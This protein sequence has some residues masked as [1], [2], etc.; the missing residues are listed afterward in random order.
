MGRPLNK[1]LIAKIIADA[2]VNDMSSEIPGNVLEQVATDTFVVET[3]DG[4]APCK[5]TVFPPA[6][7]EMRIKAFDQDGGTYYIMHL[8][9]KTA[10]IWQDT[11]TLI[12]NGAVVPWST[13][14]ADPYRVQMNN[15]DKPGG[16]GWFSLFG[17]LDSGDKDIYDYAGQVAYDSLNNLYMLTGDDTN[18]VAYLVKYDTEGVVEWQVQIHEGT[19]GV[20]DYIVAGCVLVDRNGNPNVMVIDDQ[21]GSANRGPVIMV[22][23]QDDGTVIKQRQMHISDS[24]NPYD[25]EFWGESMVMDPDDGSIYVVGFYNNDSGTAGTLLMKLDSDLNLL[26]QNGFSAADVFQEDFTTGVALTGDGNAWV[27]FSGYNVNYGAR[28]AFV[29]Q[30][31]PNGNLGVTNSWFYSPAPEMG[32]LGDVYNY[33][34]VSDSE[35][36]LVVVGRLQ[37]EV[38][39]VTVTKISGSNAEPQ[40]ATALINPDFNLNMYG[41]VTDGTDIYISGDKRQSGEQ[42]GYSQ[43]GIIKMDGAEGAPVWSRGFG[44]DTDDT[45]SWYYYS[46]RCLD[47]KNGKIATGGYTY[48]GGTGYSNAL[49]VTTNTDGE[50]VGIYDGWTMGGF[51]FSAQPIPYGTDAAE[52]SVTSFNVS[53]NVGNL[54]VV[55][56]TQTWSTTQM[57]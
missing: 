24:D 39:G 47:V 40:W 7:G 34:I 26:W 48:V 15:T 55:V 27:T 50:P 11:G 5:L 17:Y 2:N 6:P 56:S 45:S 49:V 32:Q 9:D 12:P 33:D 43:L 21:N 19:V 14:A 25:T 44:T 31:E 3:V 35:N 36:N 4:K 41:I 29:A 20:G 52:I 37:I 10:K 57:D 54:N 22:M 30:V 8:G 18:G 42:D 13:G 38:Y 46:S 16:T 28:R 51:A 53:D 23:D 1:G